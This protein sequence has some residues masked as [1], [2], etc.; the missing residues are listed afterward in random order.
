M[1]WPRITVNCYISLCDQ[2]ILYFLNA[3]LQIIE[4]SYVQQFCPTLNL[5]Y[6]H[7]SL[8]FLFKL[9]ILLMSRDRTIW[10][11]IYLY[12]RS[13]FAVRVSHPWHTFSR[14]FVLWKLCFM[15]HHLFTVIRLIGWLNWWSPYCNFLKNGQVTGFCIVHFNQ[16]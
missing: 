6:T 11:L 15:F 3:G 2:T 14:I 13:C 12:L 9:S 7:A 4:E 10:G 5:V 1:A 16:Q 8:G